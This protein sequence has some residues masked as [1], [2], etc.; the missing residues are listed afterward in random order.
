MRIAELRNKIKFFKIN[1]TVDSEYKPL[2]DY[3]LMIES[4]CKLEPILGLLLDNR[5]SDEPETTHRAT[6]RY[7]EDISSDYRVDILG[8]YYRIH[9]MEIIEEGH[10]RWLMLDLQQE[11]VSL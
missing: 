6:I 4:F 5:E 8:T 11:K 3:E 10:K 7:R 2:Y 9:Q 1:S